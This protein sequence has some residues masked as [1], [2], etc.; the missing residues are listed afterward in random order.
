MMKLYSKTIS[1]LL[2]VCLGCLVG[3]TPVWAANTRFFTL[4]QVKGQ[5]F[6]VEKP[7]K[8]KKP[9]VSG[10]RVGASAE[11]ITGANGSVKILTDEGGTV[12]LA[13][14]TKLVIKELKQDK[15]GQGKITVLKNWTGKVFLRTKKIL[16][17]NS[18][19]QIETPTAVAGVR[20]T[21]WEVYYNG[22][23]T[24]V[25][26]FQGAIGLNN[27]T[28]LTGLQQATSLSPQAGGQVERITAKDLNVWDGE[29]LS[30]AIK[31]VSNEIN[32]Q[33]R[34]KKGKDFSD[35]ELQELQKQIDELKSLQNMVDEVYSLLGLPAPPPLDFPEDVTDIIFG[36]SEYDNSNHNLGPLF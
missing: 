30:V 12:N 5:V 32:N 6:V 1:I 33:V 14:N 29:Q 25:G 18:R 27:R 24:K 2:V 26:V 3:I 16:D 23:E 34:R 7:G 28:T 31:E 11:I 20:G 9:G 17:K 15:G 21:I 4:N 10:M 35:P 22:K 19:F 36:Y 13:S 8:A